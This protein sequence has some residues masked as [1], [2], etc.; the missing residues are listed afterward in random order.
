M[1]LLNSLK[2]LFTFFLINNQDIIYC[3]Y[4]NQF[5][6]G[7]NK[8]N[9]INSSLQVHICEFQELIDLIKKIHIT[10]TVFIDR[11]DFNT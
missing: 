2:I 7:Q 11:P 1:I 9:L 6:C 10:Y 3:L 4:K 8:I 5:L